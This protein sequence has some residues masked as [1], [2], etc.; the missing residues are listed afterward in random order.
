MFSVARNQKLFS[1]INH[2]NGVPIH[3][4]TEDETA[5]SLAIDLSSL[6]D[7]WR[8]SQKTWSGLR[9]RRS[10]PIASGAVRTHNKH[11]MKIQYNKC[12]YGIGFACGGSS[13]F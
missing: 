1:V 3:R 8:R 5:A 11:V 13:L 10:R 12:V 6:H 9:V 7:S 4:T 2:A